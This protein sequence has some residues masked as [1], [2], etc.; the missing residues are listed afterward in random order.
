[1]TFDN[2][3]AYTS[4]QHVD[5]MNDVLN[6]QEVDEVNVK[7]RFFSQSLGGD[8]K[9]WFRSLSERSIVLVITPGPVIKGV[10]KSTA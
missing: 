4:H 7:M 3:S 6:H 5:R 1:M 9:K 10:P 2:T 8:L